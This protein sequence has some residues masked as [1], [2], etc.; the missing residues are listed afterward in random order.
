VA[1]AQAAPLFQTTFNCPDWNQNMGLGDAAV[2]SAGDGISGNG[3]WT[4]S[5]GSVDQITAAA[6]NPA[7]GGGKGFRHWVGD[8]LNNG[9]GGI[10]IQFS[11]RS[12][13]WIRYYIRYQSGFGWGG[14]IFHKQI[15]VTQGAPGTF[16]FGLH[17]GSIGGHV[18]VDQNGGGIKLSSMSWSAM[19]GGSTGDGQF[20]CMEI[21]VKMNST[22]TS[23]DGVFEMWHQGTQIYSASNVHFS[24]STGAA[25]SNFFTSNHNAPSNGGVDVYVDYDDIVV[26]D[27]GY[28]GPI[29]GVNI[30]APLNLRVQ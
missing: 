5:N 12:E 29:G 30:A 4:T 27:S 26:S 2:C 16:Y 24:N 20:H 13:L 15:Y 11:P 14:S 8:G 23:S 7:G 19:Q 25:W 21:H 6:N 18:E 17:A 10:G 22:G 28:I 1:R 9:G 3:G